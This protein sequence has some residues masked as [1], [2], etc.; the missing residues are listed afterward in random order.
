VAGIQPGRADT[1]LDDE[2][3]GTPQRFVWLPAEDPDAPDE[4]PEEPDEQT[5]DYL[6]RDKP[7]VPDDLHDPEAMQDYLDMVLA[8]PQWEPMEVSR[9]IRRE[10]DADRLT[11]LRGEAED[12]LDGHAMLSK[13]KVA[14]ALAIICGSSDKITDEDWD[15]AEWVMEV[16]DFTRQQ[17]IDET[18]KARRDKIRARGE[19]DADRAV[20]VER[21]LE[22]DRLGRNVAKIEKR[23]KRLYDERGQEK[24]TKRDLRD[25]IGSRP[26][27][28]ELFEAALEV[29]LESRFLVKKDGWY[30]LP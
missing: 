28:R 7:P 1:L 3:G 10:V 5:I 15:L 25:A 22:S 8:D 12:S 26:E 23:V 29:I 27:D 6:K 19:A 14:A 16:S 11:R 18:G 24:F 20:L 4:Q 17:V 2:T 13:L 30:W 9:N 21:R